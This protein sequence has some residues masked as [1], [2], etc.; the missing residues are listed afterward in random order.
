MAKNNEMKKYNFIEKN[1]LV[2]LTS[3]AI[4][5]A[6]GVAGNN[7]FSTK[8]FNTSNGSESMAVVDIWAF[9]D[10]SKK[11]DKEPTVERPEPT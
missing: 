2:G 10:S 8:F 11:D 3:K 1:D 4:D 6:P 9:F 7:N 5:A